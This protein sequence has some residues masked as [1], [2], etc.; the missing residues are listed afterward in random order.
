MMLPGSTLAC[1]TVPSESRTLTST[2]EFALGNVSELSIRG[3][4]E[5]ALSCTVLFFNMY[6][7]SGLGLHCSL[8][9]LVP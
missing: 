6:F 5:K 3:I 9:D 1:L 4:C 8:W 2:C 7:L